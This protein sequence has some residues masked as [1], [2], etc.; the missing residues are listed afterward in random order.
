MRAIIARILGLSAGTLPEPVAPLRELSLNSLMSIELRNALATE[1]ETRL[2]AT[3]VFEHPTC[4][5]LA[6]HL[7]GSISADLLSDEG[8]GD[9]L[10]GL[11][12]DAL[13]QLLEQ[14]LS[15]ANVQLAETL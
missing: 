12:A 15:A 6:A 3:L 4:A 9:G 1:C 7:A 2:S 10:D 5:A 8:A 11:N 13:A 14:E